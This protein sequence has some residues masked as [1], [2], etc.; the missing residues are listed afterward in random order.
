MVITLFIETM[1]IT[2]TAVSLHFTTGCIRKIFAMS[3]KSIH[4]DCLTW[5]NEEGKYIMY[6]II[7]LYVLKITSTVNK[8]KSEGWTRSIKPNSI[9]NFSF[10]KYT[11]AVYTKLWLLQYDRGGNHVQP[12]TTETQLIYLQCYNDHCSKPLANISCPVHQNTI[13]E[14]TITLI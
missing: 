6:S 12:Q 7:P 2:E 4:Y 14:L 10:S 13:C 9:F 11:K 3:V 8:C 1:K 5:L